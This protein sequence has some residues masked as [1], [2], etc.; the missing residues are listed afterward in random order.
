MSP[1][2][3]RCVIS[4]RAERRG[5]AE[6]ACATGAKSRGSGVQCGAG[7][8]HVVDQDDRTPGSQ[9]PAQGERT[10]HVRRP[11]PPP[12]RALIGHPARV[13]K[14]ADGVQPAAARHQFDGVKPPSAIGARR[15]GD[16]DQRDRLSGEL[17]LLAGFGDEGVDG[18]AQRSAQWP[19][20]GRL[21]G[22]V[23][24]HHRRCLLPAPGA[25]HGRPARRAASRRTAPVQCVDA[26]L[27]HRGAVDAASHTRRGNQEV[28]EF[29][30]Q[31]SHTPSVTPSTFLRRPA[32]LALHRFPRGQDLGRSGSLSESRSARS[33]AP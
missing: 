3:C 23:R 9:P 4:V 13:T 21:T 24:P 14:H 29:T 22:L 11:I 27:A 17:P 33:P 5:G 7:S 18:P 19:G 2:I 32:R 10:G 26:G 15:R 25:E 8:D 28:E 30:D 31:A 20:A 1:V 12:E 6:N 16:R